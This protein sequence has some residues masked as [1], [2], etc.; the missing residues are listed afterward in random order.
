MHY[1]YLLLVGRA[2]HN[3]WN[4]RQRREIAVFLFPL[5]FLLFLLFQPVNINFDI[6]PVGKRQL[7]LIRV[8]IDMHDGN[9]ICHKH[10]AKI[11]YRW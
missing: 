2:L 9:H 8:S 11:S 3:R 1:M 6:S 5:A 4:A 10:M 7:L